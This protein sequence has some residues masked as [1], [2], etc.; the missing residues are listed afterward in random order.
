MYYSQDGYPLE[1]SRVQTI[2]KSLVRALLRYPILY[3]SLLTA[4]VP[5]DTSYF[6][7]AMHRRLNAGDIVC[8]PPPP[9][10]HEASRYYLK[11]FTSIVQPFLPMKGAYYYEQL[12]PSHPRARELGAIV[13]KFHMYPILIP[14]LMQTALARKIR[15]F[16]PDV[17]ELVERG[18]LGQVAYAG[19]L[20]RGKRYY[21]REYE[22]VLRPF[23]QYDDV[24]HDDENEFAYIQEERRVA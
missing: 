8:E 17:N 1:I 13:R 12:F 5:T 2:E 18:I 15:D 23:L 14:S 24:L 16:T 3:R 4:L 22:E 6:E 7:E 20:R 21:L 10:S 11:R 9:V 19:D